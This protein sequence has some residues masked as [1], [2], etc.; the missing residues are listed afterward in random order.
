MIK[1]IRFIEKAGYQFP[2]S[3]LKSCFGKGENADE[4]EKLLTEMF[5]KALKNT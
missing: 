1:H 2:N 3:H 5:N 4:E